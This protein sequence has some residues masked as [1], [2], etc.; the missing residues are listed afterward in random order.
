MDGK[1]LLQ[2][3]ESAFNKHDVQAFEQYFVPDYRSEQP[4]HPARDLHGRDMLLKNWRA[5]F[6]E[7]PDFS[8]TLVRTSV[9]E[10]TLWAE[11]EWRG[12][13]RDNTQLHM[14]GVT[15]FGVAQHK[16]QWARLYVEPVE[17][18]GAGIEAAV[19]QVM[20]GKNA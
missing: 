3:L 5:N 1:A 13:R 15:I 4:S 11:W 9:D 20:H 19:Q 2:Q 6:D 10:H 14:K 12:T 7:M 18:N 16:I 17:K 8:A